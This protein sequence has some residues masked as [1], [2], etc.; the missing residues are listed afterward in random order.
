MRNTIRTL[1]HVN[2]NTEQAMDE[3]SAQILSTNESV[4]KIKDAAQL[5]TSIAEETNL[6]SL[7]ASIEAAR[8]GEQGR[9]F[10]VVADQ[11]QKLSEQSNESTKY[12][13]T[14][15]NNLMRESEKTVTF[16]HETKDVILEQSRQLSCT[17][18]QFSAIYSD[19][20]TIKQAVT[21]IYETV[22]N[23]DEE[24]LTVVDAI[25]NLSSIAE[26]NAAGTEQTLASTE[27][28][29]EMVHDISNVS[30]QLADVSNEI[31]KSVS[32]FII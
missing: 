7:N 2:D 22:R 9:G 13:D 21:A 25:R 28:V 20:E 4:V 10:A 24:R 11:I 16:M 5:I 19:I 23:V 6:L 30:D 12:I 31:E 18:E 3:I 17:E 14:I 32:G 26:G 8:A 29:K 15:V 27:L 1:S